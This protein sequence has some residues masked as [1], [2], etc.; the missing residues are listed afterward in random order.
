MT[1][2]VHPDNARWRSL[3]DRITAQL[4][5][6]LM[7]GRMERVG[8][9][10][11]LYT[12]VIAERAAQVTRYAVDRVQ[13]AAAERTEARAEVRADPKSAANA[14]RMLWRTIATNL[15]DSSPRAVLFL[16]SEGGE[17]ELETALSACQCAVREGYEVCLV[18]MDEIDGPVIERIQPLRTGRQAM[19][20]DVADSTLMVER[21]EEG[22]PDVLALP[23]HGALLRDLLTQRNDTVGSNRPDARS[24]L[25][26]RLGEGYSITFIV[27]GSVLE[28]PYSLILA[29][30]VPGVVLAVRSGSTRVE[31]VRRARAMIEAAG[32]R[33][34]GA[35][36]TNSKT[37]LAP[38]LERRL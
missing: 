37:Y 36:M 16:S 34:L 18:V 17:G 11:K 35:V 13:R 14:A 1:M 22:N 32:G 9:L 10:L 19:L 7:A 26:R 28:N 4:R 21:G 6:D 23:L 30:S 33:M 24:D 20:V 29:S 38:W 5:S 15:M 25:F 12:R 31:Q 3:L 8:Q 27:G 2:E